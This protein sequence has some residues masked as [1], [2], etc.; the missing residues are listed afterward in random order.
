MFEKIY[1]QYN[2][3]FVLYPLSM[4][5]EVLAAAVSAIWAELRAPWTSPAFAAHTNTQPRQQFGAFMR[6]AVGD[7]F[8]G[9][10]EFYSLF[11]DTPYS[12]FRFL[13]IL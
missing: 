12:L 7:G 11:P 8:T 1:T 13:N 3:R 9:P 5:F 6:L 2:V 10:P 4:L